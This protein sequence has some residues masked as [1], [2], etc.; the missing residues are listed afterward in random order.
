MLTI[1]NLT[2]RYPVLQKSF[3]GTRIVGEKTALHNINLDIP[4]SQC[5]ALAGRN[6]GGKTTLLQAISG[7]IPI[8]EG[9]ITH[10]GTPLQKQRN[11]IGLVLG[12]NLLY[13]RMTGIDNLLYT[14]RLY[15]IQNHHQAIKRALRAVELDNVDQYVETYSTGMKLKLAIARILIYDPSIILLDEPFSNLDIHM[16]IQLGKIINTLHKKKKTILIATHHFNHLNT[17][18]L[19]I[20]DKGL[21]TLD[22]TKTDNLTT[23]IKEKLEK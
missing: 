8:N 7:L 2:I 4:N 11:K 12:T 23:I 9:N 18:R 21:I 15:G 5:I 19:L 1:H 20:I 13:N 17:E 16:Q 6:G 14:T 3:W 10:N 22:T